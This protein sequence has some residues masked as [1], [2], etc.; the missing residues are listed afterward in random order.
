MHCP[1]RAWSASQAAPPP[2]LHPSSI[3][4]RG[5]AGERAPGDERR[6]GLSRGPAQRV[7]QRAAGRACARYIHAASQ[8]HRASDPPRA[9]LCRRAIS[10]SA[11]AHKLTTALPPVPSSLPWP[12]PDRSTQTDPRRCTLPVPPYG[13]VLLR[14]CCCLLL[15]HHPALSALGPPGRPSPLQPSG[16]RAPQYTVVLVLRAHRMWVCPKFWTRCAGRL[17]I[18]YY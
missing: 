15:R 14:D 9:A 13:S 18:V 2:R 10:T 7:S 4:E 11:A 1:Q 17:Y 16:G 5:P 12:P 6:G 8:Q 3:S